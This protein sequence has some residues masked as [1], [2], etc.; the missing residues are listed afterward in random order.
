MDSAIHPM[1][2]R[3]NS[4]NKRQKLTAQFMHLHQPNR[5]LKRAA[6]ST[7][8]STPANSQQRMETIKQ[9]LKLEQES[10]ALQTALHAVSAQIISLQ[11]ELFLHQ[12]PAASMALKSA[13][14][15]AIG[16][17]GQGPRVKRMGRGE[18]RDR[19][20]RVLREAGAKGASVRNIASILG[21]RAV[22]IHSWFHS[23]IKRHPQIRKSGPGTY[24]L[25]KDLPS[26]G[27][28]QRHAGGHDHES[29]SAQQAARERR[30]ESSRRIVEVLE[31]S[32]GAGIKVA[33]IARKAGLN[34]RNVYMWL[35]NE[36]KKHSRISRIG[37]GVFRIVRDTQ[38]GK[39]ALATHS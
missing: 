14:T 37:R 19:I 25:D 24:F 5:P 1:Q 22:N 12:T 31:Q 11:N 9:L 16:L 30:T 10:I 34:Y 36:T 13:K 3:C 2:S 27:F 29:A 28:S 39:T 6:A 35:A 26:N 7:T 4:K 8:N 23:A 15:A 17:D 38:A 21:L 33:D 18:L 20:L 32:S